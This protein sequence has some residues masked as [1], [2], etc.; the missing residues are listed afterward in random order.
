MQPTWNQNLIHE[1]IQASAKRNAPT[2]LTQ[3]K[4][5]GGVSPWGV[6]D[7]IRHDNLPIPFL[8]QVNPKNENTGSLDF[9][10]TRGK[11]LFAG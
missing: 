10:K 4:G 8:Q 11:V 1:Y 7:N 3:R 9:L 6:F 5:G 2:R